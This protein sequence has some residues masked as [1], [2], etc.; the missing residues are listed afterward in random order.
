PGESIYGWFGKEGFVLAGPGGKVVVPMAENVDLSPPSSGFCMVVDEE[1]ARVIGCGWCMNLAG[2]RKAATRYEGWPLTSFSGGYGTTPDGIV[3]L[4]RGNAPWR[5][6]FGR[7][8]LGTEREKHLPNV[9]AGATSEG[10]LLL[11]VVAPGPE[12]GDFTYPARRDSRALDM[13]RFDVGRGL[14]ANWFRLI[15]SA[16]EGADFRLATIEFLNA[17]SPRRL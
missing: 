14:R 16:E 13:Q 11:R 6:D 4:V 8:D 17:R 9:Y 7:L 2:D 1:Y 5:V 15:L 10:P 12:G 3:R